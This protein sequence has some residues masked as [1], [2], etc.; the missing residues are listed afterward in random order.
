VSQSRTEAILGWIKQNPELM[1]T[2][3]I[4]KSIFKSER[5]RRILTALER[6]HNNGQSIDDIALKEE[7]GIDSSFIISLDEG[8]QRI[9][10]DSFRIHVLREQI[11]GIDAEF[12]KETIKQEPIFLS[13]AP[14][15]LTKAGEL[16]RKRNE[17]ELKISGD[18]NETADTIEDLAI[19]EIPKIDWLIHPIVARHNLTILGAIKGVGKSLFVTQ[20]GL[21]AAS[22]TSP[23]ISDDIIIK[24][25]QKVL[26]I[27]QEVSEPGMKDRLEK[28]CKEKKF[29]LEGRFR[30]K[31][32]T[33]DWWDLTTDSG[34]QK[35]QGLVE[36]YE[37]DI[38][39]LDPL[40]TFAQ[41][42]VI[43]EEG[44]LP[45]M[46]KIS[47]LK[48]KYN[49][50][51]VLVH[52]FSNKGDPDEPRHM[53]GRFMGASMIANT[54]DVLIAMDFLHPKYK[55][56][57]LPLPYNHYAS[58]EITTRHGEW[59]ERFTIERQKDRL[60]FHRSAIWQE[61]GKLILPEQIKDIIAAHDGEALQKDVIDELKSVATATTIKRAIDEAAEQ[62]F[63][64]KEI[65]PGR[66][67]P[68]ILRLKQ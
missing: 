42:G 34:M 51:I 17:L 55:S 9:T 45:V 52:H 4:P 31:T 64:E 46:A 32:T 67:S 68:A 59:P 23:L 43:H 36:R 3:E 56:Q 66:G 19:K 29:Q 22:G 10:A 30:Q 60:L 54:A 28:M 47:A 40:Y 35:I 16:L 48:D 8:L 24:K 11:R 39:I 41:R 18:K 33:G 65:L 50:G 26:L 63:I 12:F 49:L 62:G 14:H 7:T 37:S 20:L 57:K 1:D 21:Y 58:L 5:E 44:I 61:L 38:L 2:C 13:G 53:S 27:Q 15:S 25:P 6:L